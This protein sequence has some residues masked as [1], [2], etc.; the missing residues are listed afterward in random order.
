MLLNGEIEIPHPDGNIKI[1]LPDNFDTDK[2]LR[3]VGKGYK[4]NNGIGNLYVKL[5]IT[6]TITLTNEQKEQIE[7]ILK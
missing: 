3:L 6:N 5:S 2:P 1:N 7:N 4:L